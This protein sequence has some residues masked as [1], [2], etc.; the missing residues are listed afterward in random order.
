MS[1]ITLQKLDL[2]YGDKI[3]DEKVDI[4]DN[5][6]TIIQNAINT[7]TKSYQSSFLLTNW[8]LIPSNDADYVSGLTLY[9][10]TITHTLNT[11]VIKNYY[12]YDSNN[13]KMY[14]VVTP[15]DA[16]HVKVISDEK[17]NGTIVLS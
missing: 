5:N 11:T 15:I 1:E 3:S 10:L 9:K 13:E 4:I 12:C 17:F 8:T 16:T 7:L 2:N 6:S 14:C